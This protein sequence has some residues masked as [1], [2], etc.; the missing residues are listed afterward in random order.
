MAMAAL[1]SV[2]GASLPFTP[3]VTLGLLL[4]SAAVAAT[5]AFLA[6]PLKV[7]P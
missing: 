6:P 1:T 2:L 4:G 7:N 5:I 3:S